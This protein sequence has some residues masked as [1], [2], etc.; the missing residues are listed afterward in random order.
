LRAFELLTLYGTP[1]RDGAHR[2]PHTKSV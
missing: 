2:N 1:V